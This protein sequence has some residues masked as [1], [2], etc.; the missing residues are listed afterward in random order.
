MG[1]SRSG[2]ESRYRRTIL[3]T[4]HAIEQLRNRLKEVGNDPLN[5][6]T[7]D[8]LGNLVDRAVMKARRNGSAEHYLEQSPDGDLKNEVVDLSDD[9][10]GAGLSVLVRGN[11]AITV[12]TRNQVIRSVDAKK[13]RKPTGSGPFATLAVLA[14]TLP[15]APVPEVVVPE[16][17]PVTDTTPGDAWAPGYIVTD[18]FGLASRHF[19]DQES[20]LKDAA[21]R[22]TS[23][24]F[25]EARITRKVIVR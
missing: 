14:P 17:D 21:R 3:I 2:T 19:D 10:Q 15:V 20:A 8:S 23:R 1:K 13:W 18:E 24:L 12:L 11:R 5:A 7:D 25:I 9:L 16:S 6:D 4:D 22:E